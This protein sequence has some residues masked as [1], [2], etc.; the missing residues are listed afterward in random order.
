MGRHCDLARLGLVRNDL[1]Y[2]KLRTYH[3]LVVSMHAATRI[4]RMSNRHAVDK[5]G[6]GNCEGLKHFY[7]SLMCAAL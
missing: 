6:N 4:A 3:L 1:K 5:Q 7:V 2:S